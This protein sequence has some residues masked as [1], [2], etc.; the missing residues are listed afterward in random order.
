MPALYGMGVFDYVGALGLAV[1]GNVFGELAVFDLSGTNVG[2]VVKCFEE[3]RFD[4][5]DRSVT[6]VPDVRFG[7][8]IH[9][10]PS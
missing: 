3:I 5:Q 2:G 4:A 10:K 6:V 8:P 1:F 9:K 7:L